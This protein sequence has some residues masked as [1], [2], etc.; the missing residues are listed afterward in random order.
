MKKVLKNLMLCICVL[1][2]GLLGLVGCGKKEDPPKSQQLLSD[3]EI[4]TVIE[5]TKKQITGT[6]GSESLLASH[7]FNLENKNYSNIGIKDSLFKDIIEGSETA[8]GEKKRVEVQTA[9]IRTYSPVLECF[10][11]LLKA[12][13]LST[14]TGKVYT[15]SKQNANIG[16]S[17]GEHM[18]VCVSS[19]NREKI[20]LQFFFVEENCAMQFEIY[21]ND[22]L[23]GAK[24]LVF[25]TKSTEL[26][27]QSTVF[28]N[29]GKISH[30]VEFECP[31]DDIN[32]DTYMQSFSEYNLIS[33]KYFIRAEEEDNSLK[34]NTVYNKV[35]GKR[36]VSEIV[37]EI[38]RN[39]S[40]TNNTELTY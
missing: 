37:G 33:G 20:T 21:C 11:V 24:E 29:Y 22:N 26:G 9:L 27:Y 23:N 28:D 38:Q 30:E 10:D 31:L 35:F 17:E 39:L 14:L 7:I 25:M 19:A 1:S 4:L 15:Y 36:D 40:G 6:E 5:G 3:K 18:N 16:L 34:T 8:D 2:L 12:T 32:K 13:N